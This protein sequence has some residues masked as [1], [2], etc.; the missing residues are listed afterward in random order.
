MIIRIICLNM[1]F[2]LICVNSAAA[3]DFGKYGASFAIEEEGFI[4]MIQRKLQSIDIEE[5]NRKM[6]NIARDRV[7][8]PVRV[9]GITK[10]EEDRE[11]YYDPTYIL[12][13]DIKLPCGKLLHKAGTSVNPLEHMKFDRRL[14]FIDGHDDSQL[15]WLRNRKAIDGIIDRVILVGGKI[16]ELQENLN[17]ELYFDQ[18]GEITSRLG[19]KHVPA[20]VEAERDKLKIN[21]VKI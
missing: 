16:L 19:I 18:A 8:N 12:K 20:I 5:H 6:V 1:F 4:A 15:E 14:I 7:I 17:R 10:A 11:F 21:E 13:E 3:K 2:L 9:E